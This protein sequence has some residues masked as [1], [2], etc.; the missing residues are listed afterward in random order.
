VLPQVGVPVD[1]A[2]ATQ[3][4]AYVN[5][6]SFTAQGLEA[7]AE[8]AVGPMKVVGSYTFLDAEVTK[9]L[10]GGALSPSFNPAFPDIPIGAFEPLVG[11]RPFRR[12]THAGTLLASYARGPAQVTLSTFFSGKQ[13]DS[14]FLSD[15]FF[16]D[17][18]LL[19]N[20][21]MDDG[22]QKVDL[23][24]SYRFHRNVRWYVTL[25]N[26]LNQKYEA[27]SGFPALPATVRTGVTLSVGSAS[28]PTP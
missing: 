6:S 14:T 4:G 8:V 9:S 11:A 27:A 2:N 20:H 17:S 3:F 5:S 10:S 21:N 16:G 15:E 13:D 19:P 28:G 12:P 25:E 7:S 23:S 24:G 26:L 18:L 22:Y 1:V